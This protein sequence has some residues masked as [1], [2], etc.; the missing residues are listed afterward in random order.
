MGNKVRRWLTLS[1]VTDPFGLHVMNLT[2][3]DVFGIDLCMYTTV[4]L[5][6]LVASVSFPASI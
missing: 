1:R 6:T 4:D 3:W 2:R 5:L